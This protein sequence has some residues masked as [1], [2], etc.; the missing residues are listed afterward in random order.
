MP[1]L[2]N[3]EAL[4]QATARF[5]ARDL[6]G[7]LKLYSN[8]VVHHGF[9]NRIRPGVAGLK[10]HY[11]ALLKGFPDTRID[12]D[13]IIAEGEKVVRRFMFFGTHKGEFLGLAPTGKMVRAP[14]VQI[15]LFHDGRAVEVWQVLDT[16]TVLSD[17]GAVSRLRDAK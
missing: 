16:F 12:I 17:I 10:D 14:G 11:M 9:S 6:D 4:Q 5:K 8:S 7:Y 3:I 15:H 13:D 1:R 2:E